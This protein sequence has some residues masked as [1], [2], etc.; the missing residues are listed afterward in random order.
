MTDPINPDY[1]R[2]GGLEAIDV[3]EAFVPNKPYRWA[4][5]KYLLRAGK[6]PGQGEVQELR[7][8]V[9]WIEREIAFLSQTQLVEENHTKLDEYIEQVRA[10][11]LQERAATVAARAPGT[12]PD[13]DQEYGLHEPKRGWDPWNRGLTD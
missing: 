11:A 13:I 10:A 5:I 12:C 2:A 9:W 3:I 1:Y 4:P 7:K 6:K 8:A